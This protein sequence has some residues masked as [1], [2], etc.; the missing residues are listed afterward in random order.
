M[1]EKGLIG[2]GCCLPTRTHLIAEPLLLL[3]TLSQMARFNFLWALIKKLAQL[4]GVPLF[5]TQSSSFPVFGQLIIDG[6]WANLG[7]ICYPTPSILSNN[8]KISS[9]L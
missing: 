3:Q 4:M 8:I 7:D 6:V 1:C 9:Q 2:Y 5:K